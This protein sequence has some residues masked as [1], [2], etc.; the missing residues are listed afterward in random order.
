MNIGLVRR[1]YSATG[2]AEAYLK[3]FAEGAAAL[4]HE[5]VLFTTGD[6]PKEE[7]PH[8]RQQIRHGESPLE[9]ALQLVNTDPPRHC[10]ILFSLERVLGCDCYRAGDGVHAAW[11]ERRKRHESRLKGWWRNRN[12]KHHELLKLEETMFRAEAAGCVIA[13]SRLVKEEIIASYGYPTERIHVIHNGV[14][15]ALGEEEAAVARREVRAELGL[16][17]GDYVLLFAGSGWDRKGLRYAIDAVNEMASARPTL[18]VAGSG[19]PRSMPASTRTRYLGPVQGMERYLAAADVFVLPT[20]YDPFSNA[21]LEATVAGLPVITTQANGFAEVMEV[22]LDG[23]A[24]AEP[25]DTL[26]LV[27]AYERWGDPE[28]RAGVRARLRAKAD[29]FTMEANVRETVEVLVAAHAA[30][31]AREPAPIVQA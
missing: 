1:G 2:G 19:R 10:D 30:K 23:D 25:G 6:W 15:P 7:W 31:Q 27:R 8:R 18:L 4:G 14:P 24:L 17:E 20:L 16:G 21:C 11:L 5:C 26:S 28:R 22:G 9:F 12:D 29:Q 3:R 13:N